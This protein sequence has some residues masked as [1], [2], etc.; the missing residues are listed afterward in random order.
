M[1]PSM[2]DNNSSCFCFRNVDGTKS[3]SKHARGLAVDINTR[4]NPYVRRRNGRL[5]VS[6]DNGRPYA[7][8]SK[9]FIYKIEK[10]DLLYRLFTEHGFRWGG[11]WNTM[12]DYQHFEKDI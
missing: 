7:D 10:D 11:N 9:T 5:H 4:Y 12:K 8:R 1:M 2:S 6:P 3:L